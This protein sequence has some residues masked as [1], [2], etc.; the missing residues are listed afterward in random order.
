MGEYQSVGG[1]TYNATLSGKGMM[2]I[3]ELPMLATTYL[4]LISNSKVITSTKA[5]G[6]RLNSISA[7]GWSGNSTMVSI[8]CLLLVTGHLVP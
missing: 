7:G 6:F 4:P 2:P 1:T 3:M 5:A 8:S